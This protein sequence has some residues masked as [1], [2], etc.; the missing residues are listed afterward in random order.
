M[1]RHRRLAARYL[2]PIAALCLAVVAPAAASPGAAQRA[3]AAEAYYSSYAPDSASPDAALATERY[4][5][6]YGTPLPLHSRVAPATATASRPSWMAAIVAGILAMLAAAGL[7]VL[8]GRA[9]RRPRHAR[10]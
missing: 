7:G 2:L 9:T 6:S 1:P 8:A 5:A 3:L 10:G 4:Y